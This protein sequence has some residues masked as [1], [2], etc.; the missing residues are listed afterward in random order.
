MFWFHFIYI[1]CLIYFYTFLLIGYDME[2]LVAEPRIGGKE[3]KT[4]IE[5][6]A[7]VWAS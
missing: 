7:Q 6:V 3:S 4:I 5:V 2:A 1:T